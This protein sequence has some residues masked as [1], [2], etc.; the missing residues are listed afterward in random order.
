M[1]H[2]TIDQ[3]ISQKIRIDKLFYDKGFGNDEY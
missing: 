1:T 2:G 3:V